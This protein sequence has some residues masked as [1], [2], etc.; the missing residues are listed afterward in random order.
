MATL[1]LVALVFL[2]SLA[3]PSLASERLPPAQSGPS[4]AM[5]AFDPDRIFAGDLRPG[6]DDALILTVFASA[7]DDHAPDYSLAIAYRCL[8]A[9][10][11]GRDRCGYVARTLRVAPG[12]DAYSQSLRLNL[13]RRAR[14]P[15][16]ADDL[17]RLLDEGSLQWL[18]ADVNACEQGIFAMD[19]VRV[20]DWNPD[21]HPA[22]QAVEDREIILH[23]ALIRVRM[24]GAYTTSRYEGW[25][26]ANGV[27]AAVG[28]LVRTLEPCWRPATSPRPWER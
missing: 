21:V 23:P 27:P 5:R 7:R 6:S 25:V 13:S 20:A 11:E 22:L 16:T 18:E 17:V 4:P 3:A 28:Q 14:D 19:S 8:P 1:R 2:S 9:E 15:A 10:T 26:L 12:E 24:T